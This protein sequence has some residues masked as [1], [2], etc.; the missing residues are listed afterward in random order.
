MGVL[1]D[2]WELCFLYYGS[3]SD[4][5]CGLKYIFVWGVK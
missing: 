4:Y 3:G 5:N 2:F 1:V